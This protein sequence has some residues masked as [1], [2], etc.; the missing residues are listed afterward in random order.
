MATPKNA[1]VKLTKAF[2]DKIQPPVREYEHH[3]D[4]TIKGYGV[5]VMPSGK[6][7]FVAMGRIRGKLVSVSLGPYGELT[8]SEA[9]E[10]ARRVLQQMRE[11][12]D[13]R[14]ERKKAEATAVTL[15]QVAEEYVSRSGKLK[16]SSKETIN[17][18]LLTTLAQW[19]QKPVASITEDACRQQYRKLVKGGLHNNRK[20]G[21]P[22]QANQA[23]SI[24]RALINYAGRRYRRADGTPLILHNPVET[25]RDDWVQLQPRTSRIPDNKVGAVWA[26][27]QDWRDKAYSREAR[28]GIDLVMWLLL[29]GCRLNEATQ[30]KFDSVHIDDERPEN[31]FW[32]IADPKNR[33]PFWFPLSSSAVEL[34]K[35][36][37]REEGS[38]FVFSS[39]GKSG[40]VVTVR[41]LLMKVSKIAGVKITAHD[42]RRTHVTIGAAHCKIDLHKVELLTGH[43]PTTVTARHYLETSHLQY[44][45]P[46]CQLITKW[47]E[48]QAAMSSGANVVPL[49]A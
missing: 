34:L 14:D 24:L 31:S 27:L 12:I 46:E 32:H 13:P 30:L 5:R 36:R 20:Q 10:K 35:R 41:D 4:L 28:T 21:S 29:T 11:G 1:P 17:R 39:W 2:I 6:R 44:L 7:V 38:D 37:D 47:I 16:E 45:H 8:E 19:S 3:W 9:R 42:L 15:A 49:R 40:H 25:L 26:A 33:H 43:L 48:N 23:F 22:G 18:H